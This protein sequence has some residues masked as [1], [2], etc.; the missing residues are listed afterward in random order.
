MRRS[1]LRSAPSMR[2]FEE[3]SGNTND[4]MASDQAA[5]LAQLK[6]DDEH[7]RDVV[8]EA[9]SLTSSMQALRISRVA[10]WIAAASLAV[11]L[12]V[13]SFVAADPKIGW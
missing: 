5:L 9:A 13:F 1:T 8:S 2:R 6:A 10:R 3:R 12:L 11:S 7:Y 4:R